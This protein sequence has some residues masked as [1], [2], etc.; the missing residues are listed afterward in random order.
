MSKRIDP[1]ASRYQVEVDGGGCPYC[2][3]GKTWT[4]VDTWEDSQIS[5]SSEDEESMQATCDRMNTAFEAGRQ[6]QASEP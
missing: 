3:H 2:G 6:A 5:E 4:V 1:N